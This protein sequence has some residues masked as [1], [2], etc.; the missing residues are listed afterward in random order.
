[1]FEKNPTETMIYTKS[2]MPS[3]ILAK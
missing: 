1:M 2:E 3:S